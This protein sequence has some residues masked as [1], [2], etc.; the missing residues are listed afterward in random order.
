MKPRKLHVDGVEYLWLVSQLDEGHVVL[1]A[2]Y[3]E[4]SRR[5]RHVEV[6]VPF[7]DPW[8]NYGAIISA[9]PE[10]VERFQLQPLTPGRVAEI[11]RLAVAQGWRSGERGGPLRFDWDSAQGL[12][13]AS[14]DW[15]RLGR[16]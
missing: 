13:L 16:A 11:I 7:H 9:P 2:W 8:L 15:P 14:A 4:G 1:K 12:T 10:A 3:A 5:F 6:R